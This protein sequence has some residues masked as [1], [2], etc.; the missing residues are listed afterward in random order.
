VSFSPGATIAIE[1]ARAQ[2]RLV[3]EK[4]D[5]RVRLSAFPDTASSMKPRLA[6]GY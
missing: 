4:V 5:R 2:S 3:E 6:L 1:Q